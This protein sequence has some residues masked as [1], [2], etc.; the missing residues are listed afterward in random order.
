MIRK[1]PFAGAFFVLQFVLSTAHASCYHCNMVERLAD[2]F[3]NKDYFKGVVLYSQNEPDAQLLLLFKNGPTPFNINR[4]TK[5]LELKLQQLR[6]NDVLQTEGSNVRFQNVHYKAHEASLK[7]PAVVTVEEDDD[8]PVNNE[9]Y[10]IAKKEADVAYKAVMNKRAV[11]F[12]MA[13][14][15]DFTDPNTQTRVAERRQLALDVVKEFNEVSKLYERA[16]HIKRTGAPAHVEVDDDEEDPATVPDHM[17]KQMLDNVRKN[18]NKMK[19]RP[20]TVERTLLMQKHEG[21]IKI[22]LERWDLLKQA[23][24][25]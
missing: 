19:K 20:P 22:L 5:E 18:Y 16:D 4:L 17:V 10:L 9:L 6:A 24:N 21:T 12:N 8:E 11:L 14:M 1:C 3:N 7:P 23:G 2:W 13:E 25:G 15:K